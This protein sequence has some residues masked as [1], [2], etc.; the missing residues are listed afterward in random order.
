MSEI[1][2]PLAGMIVLLVEADRFLAN[3]VG[4]SI[5]RA[6]GQTLGPARTVE[7]ANTLLAHSSG[8]PHAAVISARIFEAAGPAA[9]EPLTRLAVPLLL[10]AS[11]DTQQA[12]STPHAVLA[13]PFAAYQVVDHLRRI[14]NV[15][16]SNGAAL[17]DSSPALRGH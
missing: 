16:A 5:R 6:G 4:D 3:Y 1:R 10:I 2:K 15:R 12:P 11:R 9:T 8:P 17:A 13:T 14:A 7:E